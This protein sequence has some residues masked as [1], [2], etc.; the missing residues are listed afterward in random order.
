MT[1]EKDGQVSLFDQDIWCGKMSAEHSVPTTGKISESSLKKPQE[2]ATRTPLYLDLTEQGKILGLFQEPLWEMGGALLGEYT[3][4]SFGES[5]KE[6]RE[7]LLSQ[8][9][10]DKPHPKYYLSEKAC[11]GILNRAEKRGKEL[12]P[13]L[14]EALEKQ[15][16][17]SGGG[18]ITP[19]LISGQSKQCGNTQDGLTVITGVDLYNQSETGEKTMSITGAATDPHHI[20][21]VALDLF[22][23]KSTGNT[24][25]SLT[26]NANA[27]STQ[28]TVMAYGFDQGADRDVGRLF[29]EEQ[30]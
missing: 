28:P 7:S 25:N 19:T 10:E 2:C 13:L 20:P 27:T 5:P 16:S 26:C 11:R 8:I 23:Y 29:L 21:C 4:H 14:K 15:A 9:L 17:Q 22:N 24:V 6:E 30:M 3:M 12:P 18:S 1:E